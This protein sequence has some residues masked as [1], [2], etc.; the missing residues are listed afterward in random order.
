MKLHFTAG[1]VCLNALLERASCASTLVDTAFVD[2]MTGHGAYEDHTVREGSGAYT[3]IG[4][5]VSVC[6]VA[7][8]WARCR[9]TP[10]W[11]ATSGVAAHYVLIPKTSPALRRRVADARR[12]QLVYRSGPA[13][14]EVHD[15]PHKTAHSGG[16]ADLWECA[17]A[18]DGAESALIADFLSVTLQSSSAYVVRTTEHAFD[19][20]VYD[21]IDS[22][23][24]IVCTSHVPVRT[25]HNVAAYNPC[26]SVISV[27]S[28]FDVGLST[29]C[30]MST[31]HAVLCM[32]PCD[33]H[34]V[35]RAM[36]PEA[37]ASDRRQLLAYL[38]TLRHDVVRDH[39]LV[40]G[41]KHVQ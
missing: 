14:D 31:A 20:E 34:R 33:A 6:G 35:L 40:R 1:I 16:S 10:R 17:K 29:Y 5:I 37:S 13:G 30:I 15:D 22:S 2:P 9:R 3:L 11:P 36:C 28:M 27:R 26:A 32:P 7:V 12:V 23:R 19:E 41:N 18:C 38:R 39:F 24:Y 4:L 8:A 25:V 21:G